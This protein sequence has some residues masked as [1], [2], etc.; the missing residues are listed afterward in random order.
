MSHDLCRVTG[1]QPG[2]GAGEADR[3]ESSSWSENG[4]PLGEGPPRHAK[5]NSLENLSERKQSFTL[6]GP[7]LKED[8]AVFGAVR[9]APRAATVPGAGPAGN[10]GGRL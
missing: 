1:L 2:L 7:S 9:G 10:G 5:A 8:R 3:K 4:G 6:G